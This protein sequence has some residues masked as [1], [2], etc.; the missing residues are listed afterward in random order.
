MPSAC[1]RSRIRQLGA[2]VGQRHA[3][4]ATRQQLRRGKAAA[5]CTRD[6]HALVLSTEKR[7]RSFNVARLNSAKMIPM[8]TKRVITFGSLQPL[9]S[10]W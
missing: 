4:A 7:H 10:K 9:S 2:R 8:I 6:G 3:R 1:R 5:R